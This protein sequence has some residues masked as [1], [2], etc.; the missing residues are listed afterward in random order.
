M[1]VILNTITPFS[2]WHGVLMYR[3]RGITLI[4]QHLYI[5]ANDA[6]LVMLARLRYWVIEDSSFEFRSCVITME[7][8]TLKFTL[9][10]NPPCLVLFE[11]IL[12]F[13]LIVLCIKFI[14]VIVVWTCIICN[15]TCNY[16]YKNSKRYLIKF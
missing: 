1:M 6:T 15:R 8:F 13:S 9:S 4:L 14:L 16:T 2:W 3:Y 10:L 12:N 7:R 11:H 5:F